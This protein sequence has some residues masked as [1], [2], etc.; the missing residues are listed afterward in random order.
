MKAN[1]MIEETMTGNTI[2]LDGYTYAE[3]SRAP[4]GRRV[5]RKLSKE[6]GS[7]QIKIYA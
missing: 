5:L 7:E 6:D 3:I 4:R 1:A 2:T